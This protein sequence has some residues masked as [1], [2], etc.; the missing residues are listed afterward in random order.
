MARRWIRRSLSLR[1]K[2]LVRLIRGWRTTW[3]VG[4]RL[5]SRRVWWRWSIRFVIRVVSRLSVVGRSHVGLLVVGIDSWLPVVRGSHIRVGLLKVGV[6]S[7]LLGD[8]RWSR[9]GR[10]G[11]RRGRSC[12]SGRGFRSRCGSRGGLGCRSWG[13]S[14]PGRRSRSRVASRRISRWGAPGSA[15]RGTAPAATPSAASSSPGKCD[16]QTG[17]EEE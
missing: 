1:S 4:S 14:W 6:G 12:W 8:D 3:C 16:Q 15:P 10:L 2:V 9:R 17:A 11:P 13:R 5:T 7:G